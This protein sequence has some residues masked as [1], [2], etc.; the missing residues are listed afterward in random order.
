MSQ[1]CPRNHQGCWVL[2][3]SCAFWGPWRRTLTPWGHLVSSTSHTAEGLGNFAHPGPEAGHVGFCPLRRHPLPPLRRCPSCCLSAGHVSDSQAEAET[4][5]GAGPPRCPVGLFLAALS[6]SFL[7]G[8]G[9]TVPPRPV[10]AAGA[11]LSTKWLVVLEDAYPGCQGPFP[12]SIG[13]FT[14]LLSR[15]QPRTS[16]TP[17]CGVAWSVT[18]HGGAVQ[19]SEASH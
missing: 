4:G 10:K 1:T 18:A 11:V 3:G 17:L 6:L 12:W 13:L 15:W 16:V 5:L 7:L 9:V 8:N 14:G 19:A 2:L